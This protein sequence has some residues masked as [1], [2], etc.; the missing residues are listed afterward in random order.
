[1]R[2]LLERTDNFEPII[3]DDKTYYKQQNDINVFITKGHH[4]VKAK[5]VKHNITSSD[6]TDKMTL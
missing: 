2:S 4:K 3:S 5:M 1:M 6:N